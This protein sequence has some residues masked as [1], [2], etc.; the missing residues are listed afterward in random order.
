MLL[1]K[2]KRGV[3]LGVLKLVVLGRA[4]KYYPNDSLTYKPLSKV[5][6]CLVSCND[7]DLSFLVSQVV[8]ICK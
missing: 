8:H 6:Q 3:S 7:V 1:F 2:K 5:S 4:F